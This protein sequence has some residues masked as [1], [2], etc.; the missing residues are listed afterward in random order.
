VRE[1]GSIVVMV[2]DVV[3]TI[4]DGQLLPAPP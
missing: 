4:E 3:V 2:E 1:S